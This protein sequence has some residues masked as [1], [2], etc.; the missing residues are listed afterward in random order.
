MHHSDELEQVVASLFDRLVDLGLSFD[1]ALIFLFEKEKRD[2]RLWIAT[3]HL[4]APVRIDLP[5]DKEIENN[6]IIKDLW[7]AIEK[8]EH[9]LN[10]SYSGQTKND[11]FRYVAKYN[12]L[13]IPE[14]VRRLQMERDNW[15][16]YFAAEKNSIIGFDSWSGHITTDEGF[17]ILIRFARVFEQAYSRFLDLQKAEA[18]TREAKIEVALERTRTQRCSIQKNWMMP[19]G[20]FTN[21]F[22]CSVLIQHFHFY[23]YPMKIKNDTSFGQPGPKMFQLIR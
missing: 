6:A 10:R 5:Y 23:G 13:K 9:I 18:Q 11:Y 4:S 17:Q 3:T 20:F 2:I 14:A 21:K 8:G 1:G 19:Y 7:Y 16:A 12:E 22:F 15:T